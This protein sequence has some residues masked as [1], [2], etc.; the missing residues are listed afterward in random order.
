MLYWCFLFS[1]DWIWPLF[2][3]IIFIRDPGRVVHSYLIIG[4]KSWWGALYMSMNIGV[5][6]LA[7]FT[8]VMGW[9]VA[10]GEKPNIRMWESFLW[11]C[12]D[13]LEKNL[14]ISSP[15]KGGDVWG[16]CAY[17]VAGVLRA[18]CVLSHFSRVWLFVTLWTYSPWVPG[19]CH[20]CL[21]NPMDLPARLLCPWDFPGKNTEVDCHF[22]LQ[23][24]FP[25]QG[26]KLHLLYLLRWQVGSLP[27]EPSGVP[28]IWWERKTRDPSVLI[29]MACSSVLPLPFSL[30]V[31]VKSWASP[32]FW[33]AN[34]NLFA[35]ASSA[36]VLFLKVL[37]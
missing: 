1:I 27:L 35:F 9:E 29:R 19:K 32:R 15:G 36:N 28:C 10:H 5:C 4:L 25:T 22:L 30:A 11:D 12:S 3:L 18:A 8:P 31:W 20:K 37:F 24:I 23:G 16:L 21:G 34:W 2:T 33:K 17:L 13:Y 6:H 14:L 7:D 26:L